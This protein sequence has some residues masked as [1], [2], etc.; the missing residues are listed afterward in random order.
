[1]SNPDWVI[2]ADD[3]HKEGLSY[4]EIGNTL[5]FSKNKVLAAH[6]KFKLGM[7][8]AKFYEL[9]PVADR[10]VVEVPVRRMKIT[11][12]AVRGVYNMKYT[13]KE[14]NYVAA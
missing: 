3:M 10:P 5:G 1:M 9:N 11:L 2:I 14:M 13:F 12:P 7:H 4:A 6:R 8:N